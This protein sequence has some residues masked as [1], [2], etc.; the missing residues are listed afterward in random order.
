MKKKLTIIFFTCIILT[1]CA[2]NRSYD[3]LVINHTGY[4]IDTMNFGCNRNIKQISVNPNDTS[5]KFRIPF[6]YIFAF[7]EPLLCVDISNYSDST[8]KY[9]NN[10][11]MVIPESDLS[12]KR[13]N[14]ITVKLYEKP[15]NRSDIFSIN[16]E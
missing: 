16:I 7:S 11:G 10:K 15:N 1:G 5:N 4:K 12:R 3:I 2:L 14:V 13:Q 9:K 8:N 6:K